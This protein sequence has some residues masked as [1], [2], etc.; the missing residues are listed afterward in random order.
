M[1][2]KFANEDTYQS[3]EKALREDRDGADPRYKNLTDCI[4]TL[5]LMG[6]GSDAIIG[7]DFD[8]GSF[9]FQEVY[10]DGTKGLFGGI[11]RHNSCAEGRPSNLHYYGIHT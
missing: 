11:I 8:E 4:V 3:F 1:N 7:R 5:L 2:I 6:Y 10:P 9:T